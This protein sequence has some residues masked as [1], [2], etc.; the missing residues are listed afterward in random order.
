MSALSSLRSRPPT[1][2]T[3]H[4]ASD[5]SI[6]RRD[7]NLDRV[8]HRCVEEHVGR[9]AK[10][11]FGRPWDRESKLRVDV[12]VYSEKVGGGVGNEL[13]RQ[14]GLLQEGEKSLPLQQFEVV[15]PTDDGAEGEDADG[16]DAV[17]R[18]RRRARAPVLGFD[19]G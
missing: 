10:V 19:G 4:L 2:S 7:V 11:C 13:G 6:R 16:Q 17:A 9:F 14:R 8:E 5:P 15:E 12:G 1:T 3:G 18:Y